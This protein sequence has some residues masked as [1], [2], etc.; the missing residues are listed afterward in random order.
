[1]NVNFLFLIPIIALLALLV[2]LIKFMWIKKQ[3][4]GT[5]K[6]SSIALKIKN[7]AMT[8]S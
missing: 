1:M 4:E 3:S 2:A 6:M 5:E 7:G 8:L